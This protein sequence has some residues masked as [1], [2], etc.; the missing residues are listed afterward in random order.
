MN[1][2]NLTVLNMFG[3]DRSKLYLQTNQFMRRPLELNLFVSSGVPVLP[4]ELFR[5]SV[6][7]ERNVIS[8]LGYEIFVYS[9]RDLDRPWVQILEF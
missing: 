5:K 9:V 8:G 6:F 7:L 2:S 4:Y 3:I 1:D